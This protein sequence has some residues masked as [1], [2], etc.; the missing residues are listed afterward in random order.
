MHAKDAR[1]S[2][3]RLKVFGQVTAVVEAAGALD[4][5]LARD[6]RVRRAM[7]TSL[8]RV[9]P[10]R[11]RGEEAYGGYRGHHHQVDEALGRA[12]GPGLPV[13]WARE[14]SP[15]PF[16][17]PLSPSRGSTGVLPP[18]PPARPPAR[19]PRR[20]RPPPKRFVSPR[21]EARESPRE[22]Q[23]SPSR[24]RGASLRIAPRY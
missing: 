1:D 24:A 5:P 14:L 15:P 23:D 7:G 17:P 4:A 3:A 20:R 21:P 19:P 6:G 10:R 18:A 11:A 2:P 9:A 13:S 16:P 22:P 12:P 8:R